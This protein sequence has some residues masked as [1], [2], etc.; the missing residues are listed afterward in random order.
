MKKTKKTIL[1]PYSAEQMYTL[2]NDL[3]GYKD[4]LP[5]CG[6]VEIFKQNELELEAKVHIDFK[7]IKQFFHTHNDLVLN[8]S[9][10]MSFVDGPFK[11]FHGYWSFAELSSSACKVEFSLEYQ[12]SNKIL[13]LVVGPLF[14]IISSTFVD[15]FVKRAKT[16]YSKS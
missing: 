16:I 13:E 2:V 14:N 5:W 8:K 10:E 15:G 1:L 11:H 7:G 4:F 6:G 9:I 3:D 12:F